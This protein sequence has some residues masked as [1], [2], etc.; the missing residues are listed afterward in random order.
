MAVNDDY[1]KMVEDQLSE[2]GEVTSKKMFGGVGFYHDGVMFGMIGNDTFRLKVDE[3]N[4]PDFEARGMEPFYAKNKKKGMPYWEVPA[5]VLEDRDQ[6]KLW[7]K[8]A[9]EAALRGKK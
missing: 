8:K 2:F 1:L 9:Y 6:L 4:Q 7:A 5:D 3:V